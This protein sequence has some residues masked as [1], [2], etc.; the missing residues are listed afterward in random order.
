[1]TPQSTFNIVARIRHD[2]FEAL[3]TLLASMNQHPGFADPRNALVPYWQ[4]SQ[5]HFARF[6]ILEANTNDD[7]RSFGIE[8]SPWPAALCFAGDVD[9]DAGRFLAELV[10]RAESGLRRI[11]G[12]C[13]DLDDSTDLLR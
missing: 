6:T 13:E 10:I 12:H 4:L 5:L 9:G 8:P 11:F 7:I 1:M 3:R 2:R